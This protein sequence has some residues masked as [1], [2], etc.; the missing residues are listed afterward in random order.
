MSFSK[1]DIFRKGPL[2][3][4]GHMSLIVKLLLKTDHQTPTADYPYSPPIGR[5]SNISSIRF[6]NPSRMPR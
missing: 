3:Q 4:K 1:G 5:H 2:L 6:C